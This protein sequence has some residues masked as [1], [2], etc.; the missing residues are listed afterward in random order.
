[1]NLIRK[2]PR[3]AEA[4]ESSFA[5]EFERRVVKDQIKR[6]K[7]VFMPAPPPKKPSTSVDKQQHDRVKSRRVKRSTAKQTGVQSKCIILYYLL[8]S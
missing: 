7:K 6:Q 5:R 8:L 1:M 2:L 3:L 4:K